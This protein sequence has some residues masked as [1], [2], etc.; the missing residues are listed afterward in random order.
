MVHVALSGTARNSSQS[1]SCG[2]CY[3]SVV[4][5]IRKSGKGNLGHRNDRTEI[6][7]RSCKDNRKDY[8]KDSSHGSRNGSGYGRNSS[9][10][11]TYGSHNSSHGSNR[12]NDSGTNGTQCSYEIVS[13]Y[14]DCDTDCRTDCSRC[15]P[16]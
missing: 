14:F 2:R 11:S 5:R 8:G 16:I 7:V 9:H 1:W 12:R 6:C 13:D 10:G 15:R 4:N 3:R